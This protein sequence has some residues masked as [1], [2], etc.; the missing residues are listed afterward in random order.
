M[1]ERRAR[2]ERVW[3][4][5]GLAVTTAFALAD[6]AL[7]SDVALVGLLMAGP[8]ISALMVRV[9]GTSVVA[10]YALAVGLLLGIPDDMFATSDH[11][12]R[13]GTVVVGDAIAVAISIARHRERVARRRFAMLAETSDVVAE[14]DEPEDMLQRVANV[15]A[16]EVADWTFVF[17][18]DDD[19]HVQQVAA[20]H[21]DRRR[22]ELAWELLS[23]YPL[24]PARPEG[25]AAVMRDGR[26]RLYQHVDSRL[27]ASISADEENLRLLERLE[28]RSVVV[29][30]LTA[31]GRTFGALALA[32]AESGIQLEAE[33][34]RLAEEVADRLATA[35]DNARL[36]G[37]LASAEAE[38]RRSRDE[39]Q[40]ILDG[41]ADAI[42]AQ[43]PGSHLVFANQAAVE[44]MGF[45]SV[46]ELLATPLAEIVARFEF[47]DEDGEPFPVERLPG[48]QALA[49]NPAPEPALTRFR[50]RGGS[51]P[52]RWMRVKALPV[53][54]D[55]GLLAINIMEDVTEERAAAD[56]QRFLAEAGQILTS[57]L[58]YDTTLANVARLAVPRIAD[59]CAVDVAEEEGL[60]PVVV[61]HA[62][63]AKV[64]WAQ[65]LRDRYP[66]DPGTDQ[67]A[68]RVLR[69]GEPELYPEIPDEL[70]VE[71]AVDE[72]HLRL[73]RQ[74][75]FKSAMAVP[76]IARGRTLGVL[77]LVTSDSGRTL[78]EDDMLLAEELAQRCAMAVD[79]SRLFRDRAHIARTLQASLLPPELPQPAG[80]EVAA[81][82]RA[83]GEGY[84]V[85]GDFYDVFDTGSQRW[86]AVIGDV[87]G[88]GP[89]A[90]A[91][92]ALARYTLRAAAM[93]EQV[94][95]RILSTLNEAMLR[96][97]SDRRF[98]T[99]LYASIEE[100]DGGARAL[101]FASGGHPLPLVFRASGEAEEAGAP[102][103]LLGIVPD[104]DLFDHELVLEPGDAAVLY[105]DGVTDAAAPHHVWEPKELAALVRAHGDDSA[106]AI[107][108]RLLE[109]A[110]GAGNGVEP[111]DDIALL[112]IRVPPAAGG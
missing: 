103:T 48:R 6:L 57:S 63:P 110:L 82:F 94:P 79:N 40:A 31:H 62:D 44:T 12:S 51:G 91:L 1:W 49:G 50:L 81:R 92:T 109:V 84:D 102:G 111:R 105:T 46:E 11:L 20:A 45:A 99:V 54:G 38:L 10:L 100:R 15:C 78:D 55:S 29:V 13:L 58:D 61:A 98:S 74:L 77:T 107:A 86:A 80:L 43:G 39:L 72:E 4:V 3:T 24:D 67:G 21:A 65:E 59:W 97:R 95:S 22:Q 52:E 75:G 7:G 112:V 28:M 64:A 96:Q 37:Q 71:G 14:S 16:R 88:K 101:R 85:G 23:R 70:L 26:S 41:V 9:P 2:R 33:D 106:D 104:P 53:G 17:L 25:P 30:P 76:L 89:E 60:R 68:Y 42:T 87:C 66:P 83:A 73:L 93:T 27:L 108:G 35:V 34:L 8:L 19:G 69:T 18:R 32:T 47:F 90:A 36:Y 5:F 56:A